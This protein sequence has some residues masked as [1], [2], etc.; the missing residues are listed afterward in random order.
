VLAWT[1][2]SV[3]HSASDTQCMALYESLAAGVPA[4]IY[5]I[6]TLMSLFPALPA[7]E[8]DD[9]LR[10]TVTRLLDDVDARRRLVDAAQPELRRADLPTHDRV[11]FSTA[12][13][14]LGR[15]LTNAPEPV[16][17]TPEPHGSTG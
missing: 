4:T 2:L 3:I 11:F 6:P 17:V 5:A 15:D 8:D 16:E 7:Y 12:R 13:R 9:S 1:D 14:L 10:T